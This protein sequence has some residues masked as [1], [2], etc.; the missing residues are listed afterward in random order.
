MRKLSLLNAAEQTLSIPNLY[1]LSISQGEIQT[2]IVMTLHIP[3]VNTRDFPQTNNILKLYL[4]TILRSTCYNEDHL[5]F[6]KEVSRTEIGHLF[7]HIL[8]E[9]LCI[10]KL[11]KG[12]NFVSYEGVTDWNWIRDP[13]G[14]FH[15]T[16]KAN[17]EELDI[18]SEA[19]DRSMSL[20]NGILSKEETI[21]LPLKILQTSTRH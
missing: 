5:P 11:E 15:I 10:I 6:H 21:M 8:L 16:I 2:I 18:L 12:Y 3:E 19:L 17:S 7:E 14:T 1:S 9:F 20:L 4:P 13:K